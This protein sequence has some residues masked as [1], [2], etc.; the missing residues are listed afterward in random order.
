MNTMKRTLTLFLIGVLIFCG[1]K[2]KAQSVPLTLER[3]I[4]IAHSRS[5]Q[6]Q[7][8]QLNFMAQYW[9]YRSYKAQLLPSL[10]LR[11]NLANYNRSLTEVIDPDNGRKHYV[12]VNSMN[13]QLEVSIDQR[14]PFT[15]GTISLNTS[16]D[17]LDQFDYDSQ[18]YSSNPLTLRYRQPLRAFNDLKWQKKTEPLRYETAKRVYLEAMEDIT[19]RTSMQFFSVLSMQTLHQKN[20]DNLEDTRQMYEVAKKRSEIGTVT[21]TE[22]LQLEL[23]LMNA[24]LAAS[25]SRTDLEIAQFDFKM[26]LGLSDETLFRFVAPTVTPEVVLNYDFVL[27]KALENSSQNMSLQLKELESQKSVAE[28][29]ALR[30]LQM[31]LSA[32]VGFSQSGE[33]FKDAYRRLKDQEIVGISLSMPIYDWG[34]SKGKVR[35]AQ[36]Q[37]R[38]TRTQNEQE[39]V[40]YQQDIRVK[41]MKFNQQGWQCE[42]SK[43][44]L[45]VAQQRYEM[46]KARFQNGG[47][48]VTDLNTA[49]KELDDASNQYISNIGAFWN[50]YYELRKM[51]LYDFIAQ[52]DICVEFD[53]IIDQE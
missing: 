7:M 4:E 47:I 2:T 19:L 10:N 6:V 17:R 23:A 45:N 33:N 12:A 36:A 20:L 18:I 8:T 28:A 53:K 46:T 27:S 16:L 31:E 9:S 44:A 51:T 37:A 25:N 21:H 52:K 15:G 50:V 48:T 22:L 32:N 14:I 5:P 34:M 11:G 13:N 29:K 49:Q 30:G 35:M 40:K 39:V 26:F 41:V 38:L 42:I 3:A 24:E 43:K 1:A